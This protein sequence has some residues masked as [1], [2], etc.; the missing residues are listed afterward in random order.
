[1]GRR[2]LRDGRMLI[3]RPVP[4]FGK[5]RFHILKTRSLNFS[6][7]IVQRRILIHLSRRLIA[8]D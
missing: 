6:E 7:E 3:R 5:V 1:M 4:T 2:I 8:R